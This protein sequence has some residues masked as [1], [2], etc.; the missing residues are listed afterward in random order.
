M[1]LALLLALFAGTAQAW[2]PVE[3]CSWDRPGAD[4]YTG[5]TSAAVAAYTGIPQATRT[6]LM[7]RLDKPSVYD[8]IIEI[9][10]DSVTPGYSDLFQMHFGGLGKVC[11]TVTRAGWKA[12][13]LQRALVYCEDGECIAVP[14]VCGNV[15]RITR[16]PPLRL[17][18]NGGGGS[19]GLVIE[20]YWSV[21]VWTVPPDDRPLIPWQPPVW[22]EWEPPRLTPHIP[23]V[24]EP[25][26]AAMLSCG[27]LALIRRLK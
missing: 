18:G 13:D 19:Y 12:A 24:P 17:E 2:T 23:A 22:R 21:V 27:L 15:S 20:P 16:L 11:Q 1:K 9:R 14:T 4:R 6:R 26:T 5:T 10:R 8:D 25:E 7:A 3:R